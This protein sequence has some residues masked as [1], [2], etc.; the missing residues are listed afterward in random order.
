M[1]YFVGIVVFVSYCVHVYFFDVDCAIVRCNYRSNIVI[2]S[3][4]TRVNHLITDIFPLAL[5]AITSHRPSCV[6]T[7]AFLRVYQIVLVRFLLDV[8]SRSSPTVRPSSRR[9]DP[10]MHKTIFDHTLVQTLIPSRILSESS[11]Y[12]VTL[13]SA[14]QQVIRY[15]RLISK[16]GVRGL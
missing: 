7:H 10:R 6:K 3:L 1:P 13:D 11:I 4:S 15:N 14:V 2:L 9:I 8:G 16:S 5:S 12:C